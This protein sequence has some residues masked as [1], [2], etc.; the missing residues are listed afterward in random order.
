MAAY[1]KQHQEE[2]KTFEQVSIQYIELSLK[3]LAATQS[4]NDKVN[5]LQ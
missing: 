3:D 1:Y 4:V 2:F 5:E